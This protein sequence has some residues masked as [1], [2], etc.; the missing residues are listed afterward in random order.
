RVVWG[1]AHRNTQD[2]IVVNVPLVSMDPQR[3]VDLTYTAFV[4]DTVTLVPKTLQFTL[5]TKFEHNDYSKNEWQPNARLAWTPDEQHVWWTSVSRA[6][7]VK[8]RL[9]SD[10][11]FFGVRLGDNEQT[12]QVT[13]YEIGHRNLV[14]KNLWFDLAAFYNRYRRLLT[15]EAGSQFMNKMH[16]NTQGVE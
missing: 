10:L 6:V 2:N 9:E 14:T 4:Q 16:G 7:R 5:G 13:A 11:T 1:L 15:A 3:R 12:E 8:S